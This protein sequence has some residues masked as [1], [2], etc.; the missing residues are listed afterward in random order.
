MD[1][2]SCSAYTLAVPGVAEVVDSTI[3]GETTCGAGEA[4]R[5]SN[6]G[7]SRCSV[8]VACR[9]GEVAA[10]ITVSMLLHGGARSAVASHCCL[11][12]LHFGVGK[13]ADRR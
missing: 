5:A 4:G 6:G 9:N 8:A 2:T 12:Q 3:Q 13:L 10:W 11:G 7:G 1:A